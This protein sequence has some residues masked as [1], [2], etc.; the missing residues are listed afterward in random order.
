MFDSR[1]ATSCGAWQLAENLF[2]SK[3]LELQRLDDGVNPRSGA[4]FIG[5]ACGRTRDAYAADH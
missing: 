1:C 3:L 2:F 5:L 4:R